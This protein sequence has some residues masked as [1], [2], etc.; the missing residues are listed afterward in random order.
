MRLNFSYSICT[1]LVLIFSAGICNAQTLNLKA[2]PQ[3]VT[4]DGDAKEWGD[5]LDYTNSATKLNYTLANDKDNLYLV[6][7][8][9]AKNMQTDILGGG[10]TLS[11]D[12]K[13]RKRSTYAVTFPI[14]EDDPKGYIN[15]DAQQTILMVQY[16]KLKKIKVDGFSDINDP[17]IANDNPNGIKV[18]MTY[19]ANGYLIY[20]E[21]VPLKLFHAA[22]LA[23][24]E[25]AFNIK[26]NGLQK[27]VK[28][29]SNVINQ[30]LIDMPAS[31]GRKGKNTAAQPSNVSPFQDKPQIV[32]L[33]PSLDFWGKFNLAKN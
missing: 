31:G 29:E 15:M 5:S 24:K 23:D 21:A 10:V 12:A 3:A 4:I 2:A 33:T 17:Q 14:G 8:T 1:G 20:E 13:G 7:K 18:A 26:L 25:W 30:E 19:D 9:K 27:Q 28:L 6:I 11:I 32:Q 16:I 22:N